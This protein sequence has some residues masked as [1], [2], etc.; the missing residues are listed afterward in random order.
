MPVQTLSETATDETAGRADALVRHMTEVSHSQVRGLID[1]GCVTVNGKPCTDGGKPV[2]AG[3]VVSIRYD[4]TQRYRPKKER[5]WDDR[6]FTIAYEDDHVIVVDKAAGTL[7]VPTDR[8][9][10][11]TLVERVSIYLSH[12]RTE[13][14]AC[15]VHRLDREASGLLVFGKHQAVADL[16]IEQ[17]KERKPKRI[18]TAIVAG[19]MPNDHGT[20]RAHLATGKNLDRYV[21]KPSKDTEEV[22]T[23]YRVIKRME[24]STLVETSLQTGKRNQIRVQLSY[25]G[26]PVLGD[27]HYEKEKAKHPRWIRRRMALHANSLSFIHPVSG[28][29]MTVTS[30]LPAAMR[31]FIK[32]SSKA[33]K[34]EK[35]DQADKTE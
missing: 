32:V 34:W 15:L 24:D 22:V 2:A 25:A 28:E 8:G 10:P 14:E 3:D 6:T 17:F 5:K 33:S 18:Y 9:D 11:N 7:S 29:E 23:D 19:C 27:P 16:L 1:R 12:S 31:K 20:L 21:T 4:P 35:S 26:H 30:A 13:R